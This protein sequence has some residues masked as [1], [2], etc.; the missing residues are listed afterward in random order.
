M[1]FDTPLRRTHEAWMRDA[2][3]RA[4]PVEAAGARPGAATG[5]RT[6][7]GTGAGGPEYITYG[8]PDETGAPRCEVPAAYDELPLEY[9][10]IRRG[11]GLMDRPDRG[12]VELRGDDRVDLLDRL[13][14]Q[15]AKGLGAGGVREA[16]LLDRKGRIRADLLVV[17]LGDRMLV[18]ADAHVRELVAAEI[19]DMVFTEDVQVAGGEDWYRLSVHGAAAEGVL[20]AITHPIA[21][22]VDDLASARISVEGVE[23]VVVRRDQVG[24]PGLELFVRREGRGGID[25]VEAVWA[26]LL[27]AADAGIGPVRP[28]GWYAWNIARVEA[29]TPIFHVDFGSDAL[30]AETGLLDRRVS[31]TKGCYP[32]QE[33]VA[34]M[35]HLGRPKRTL[36]GL[37]VE[38]EALP[39]AGAQVFAASDGGA[40]DLGTP[41]GTVTSST[42]SP[43]LGLR[44]AVMAMVKI[45]HAAA[46]TRLLVNAEGEQVPATVGPLRSWPPQAS[47][48]AASAAATDAGD[49]GAA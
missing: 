6:A 31:F 24:E 14:T 43:M 45:A 11:A 2:A 17:E 16:F 49:G 30:P 36:V 37:R 48:P 18:D 34:R 10:A 46:G 32:G 5:T 47:E 38:G 41:V 40:S 13:V 1:R 28:V 25:G 15:A 20:A 27:H 8:P 33:V 7:G 29:G 4:T 23:V 9:A 12:V 26:R 44:P 3:A 42:P 39:I 22:G 21:V 35:Q 19:D